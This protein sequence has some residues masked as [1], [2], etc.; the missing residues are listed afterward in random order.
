MS[1]NLS[2]THRSG[3]I[4]SSVDVDRYVKVFPVLAVVAAVPEGLNRICVQRCGAQRTGAVQ[5]VQRAANQIVRVVQRT[6]RAGRQAGRIDVVL[7]WTGLL[8][9]GRLII[10]A[11]RLVTLVV[12]Q[13]LVG[14][15]VVGVRH[16]LRPL[17]HVVLRVLTP[18]FGLIEALVRSLASR[19]LVDRSLVAAVI[20]VPNTE[21]QRKA[22]VIQRELGHE[23]RR[24]V[25]ERF[26]DGWIRLSDLED[27]LNTADHVC[28]LVER[29]ERLVIVSPSFRVEFVR[30]KIIFN[31]CRLLSHLRSYL[32]L[33]DA[34][35]L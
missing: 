30:F 25:E 32:A 11:W 13:L 24:I 3:H 20:S 1:N 14:D 28:G 23:V 7:D 33:D 34:D 6:V 4:H 2:N 5:L 10:V 8:K 18:D 22:A 12:R 19:C 21:L 29:G 35:S 16:R 27:V 9:A 15:R 26:A 17:V 31:L